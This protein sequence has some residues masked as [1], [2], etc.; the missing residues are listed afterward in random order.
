[1]RR[2]AI[3]F[4]LLLAA[5]PAHAHFLWLLPAG[6]KG[7]SPTVRLVF[8]DALKPDDADLLKKIAHTEVFVRGPDDKTASVKSTQDKDALVIDLAGKGPREIGAVCKYGVL[9]RG[10]GDPFLLNYYA[11]TFVGYGDRPADEAKK[12]FTSAWDKLALDLVIETKGN[13]VQVLW[14]GKPLPD[15]EAVVIMPG[16]EDAKTKSDKEGY[17]SLDPPAQNGLHGLRVLHTENK[18]GEHDGKAYKQIKHYATLVIDVE[19]GSGKKEKPVAT[20][21]DEKKEDAGATKLLADARAARAVW[22]N[23]PGFGADL[24]VNIDGKTTK[25]RVEVS[26]K[27]KVQISNITDM[28]VENWARRQ[29]SSIVGHRLDSGDDLNTP[30]AFADDVTDHP[31]GRAIRVLNDEFHSSYRIRDR[32]VIEVN[33]STKD[34]RFTITVMENRLSNEKQFLPAVYVVNTW[35]KKTN[36]LRSSQTFYQDFVRVGRFD[37]PKSELMVTATEGKLESRSLKLSNHQLLP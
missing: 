21:I 24:E 9:K 4:L 11:K 23:F 30:C 35:D 37:L 20:R 31:L 10:E 27:G 14:Q 32:Q 19:K 25:G 12:L 6:A 17:I 22:S 8:S 7:D 29:L 15:A 36:A 16:K 33:R 26:A 2:T 1:M 28:E 18:A 3:L 34:G 13:R 5:T